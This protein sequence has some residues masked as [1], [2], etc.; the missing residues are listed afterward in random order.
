M[1]SAFFVRSARTIPKWVRNSSCASRSGDRS[2]PYAISVT[3]ITGIVVLLCLCPSRLVRPSPLPQL[4]HAAPPVWRPEI[5]PYP[6]VP[7]LSSAG[8]WVPVG[9]SG[10]LRGAPGGYSPDAGTQKGR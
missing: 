6:V 3:L 5:L 4:L 10:V 8:V 1:Y 7:G 2:F 9:F